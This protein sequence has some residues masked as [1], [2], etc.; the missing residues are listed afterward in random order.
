MFNPK[1]T[2][3][4]KLLANIKRIIEIITGLNNHNFS[5]IVLLD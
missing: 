4:N 3:S 2:I 1:Y 5:N